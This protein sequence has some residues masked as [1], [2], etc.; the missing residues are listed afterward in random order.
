G[1]DTLVTLAVFQLDQKNVLAPDP[2]N[3]SFNTQTGAV[4][5]RG[6]ELEAKA[7]VTRGLDVTASYAYTDSEIRRTNAT[8][9]TG[10]Q[11]NQMAFVPRHQAGVWVDYTF[12]AGALRGH[13]MGAGATYRGSRSE[14]RRV[15]KE[16]R[17]R[18]TA[19]Q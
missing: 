4:R 7:Q 12:Q 1:S 18:W 3:T 19:Y 2:L 14:E 15:G 11:G 17:A 6:V 9:S 8:D 16:C 10:Q 13:G 5:L